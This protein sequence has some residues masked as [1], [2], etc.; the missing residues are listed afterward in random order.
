M[1]RRVSEVLYKL[2][3]LFSAPADRVR[4]AYGRIRESSRRTAESVEQDNRRMSAS[5]GAIVSRMRGVIGAF[6]A[7]AGAIGASRSISTTADELD[8]LGKTAERLDIDPQ[9]LA[10]L[11]FGADR[12][13]V[14]VNKVTQGLTTFQKR[15]GEALQGIGQA[16]LALDRFGISAE[17]FAALGL[18]EQ[19]AILAD[20]FQGLS[21]QEE[22]AAL[23]AQLFS[24]GNSEIILLLQQGGEALRN[25]LDQAREFRDV[26]TEQTKAAAQYN[27]AITNLSTALEG[28]KFETLAP[29]IQN[30]NFL[31]GAIGKLGDETANLE[32][33]LESAR[34]ELEFWE[35]NP[36]LNPD[37]LERSRRKVAELSE[38][39]DAL[40]SA[41]EAAAEANRLADE[42]L[43]ARA[44]ENERYKASV[45][46][47]AGSFADQTDAQKKALDQQ[48][49]ELKRARADMVKIETEFSQLLENIT[50]LD[51]QDVFLGD[52]FGK[53]NQ[54]AAA[55]ARGES[56][57]ALTLARQGGT[58][59]EQL[60]QKG[61]ETDGTLRFLA[62]SL[63]RVA[64]EAGQQ[65]VRAELVDVDQAEQAFQSIKGKLDALKTEAAT[66][67]TDIGRAVVA[68]I[69]AELEVADLQLPNIQIPENS[70]AV[71]AQGLAAWRDELERRGA[72]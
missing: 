30:I 22:R 17:D 19:L 7:V 69:R 47:L 58:L 38:A 44:Q 67:G 66:Q 42:Q 20:R 40:A 59:L 15:L 21:E 43:A 3:D 26:T 37:A 2:R 56:E 1:T 61:T 53:I 39:I 60:K 25:Y 49:N 63:R 13:G 64:T 54:G 5:F 27:D 45:D 8:R 50:A 11:E 32:A 68:A 36:G 10:G 35:E 28:I 6:A 29:V 46:A 4:A 34:R 65:R 12:S 18:E 48:R 23:G 51:E 16:R 57:R 71:I 33:S 24:K 14:A 70:R 41:Q 52:V 9:L 72:K 55:A 62:E 31:L